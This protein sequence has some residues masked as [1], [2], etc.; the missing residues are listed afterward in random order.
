MPLTIN[1]GLSRKNSENFNSSGTSINVSAE[2]DQSLLA[3]PQ[4]L[5][6]AIGELYQQA[7]AALDQQAAGEPASPR[8]TRT[9]SRN[10]NGQGQYTPRNSRTAAST[11][12]GGSM[13]Q[14][15]RR[16]I[17]A[18]A[19]ALDIDPVAEAREALNLDLTQADVRQARAVIDHLKSLQG[20]AR[21][22]G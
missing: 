14:S 12:K 21:N 19:K 22:G 2:L 11:T 4:E 10:G 16:A 5:Q 15:Q 7:E 17:H 9:A 18:I 1:V 3:R 6:A 13:T 8:A 20:S